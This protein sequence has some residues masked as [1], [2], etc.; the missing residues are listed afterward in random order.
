VIVV[1]CAFLQ[2]QIASADQ[3]VVAHG[4]LGAVREHCRGIS[5]EFHHDGRVRLQGDLFDLADLDA[6]DAH[7]IAAFEAADIAEVRAVGHAVIESQLREDR[8]E[9]EKC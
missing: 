4:C 8:Y 7:E 3:V 9:Q 1:A 6:G 5:G 2:G